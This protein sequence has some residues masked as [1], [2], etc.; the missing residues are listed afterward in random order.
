MEYVC[1]FCGVPTK[2]VMEFTSGR[3]MQ[4][5]RCPKCWRESPHKMLFLDKFEDEPSPAK[6]KEHTKSPKQKPVKKD[7]RKK[8]KKGKKNNNV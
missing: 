5:T 4:F 6:P 8:K 7:L 2:H 1:R 3:P